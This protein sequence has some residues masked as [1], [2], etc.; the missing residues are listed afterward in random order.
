MSF[1]DD[2]RIVVKEGQPPSPRPPSRPASSKEGRKLSG[3]HCAA[4]PL[5]PSSLGHSG[6]GSKPSVFGTVACVHT[7]PT[8]LVVS[9]GSD[10]TVSL[11]GG[12]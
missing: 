10:G 2:S 9:T 4:A 5:T 6:G 1:D 8:G 11:I 7:S 12:V 3:N